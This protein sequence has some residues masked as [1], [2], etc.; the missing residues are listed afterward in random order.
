VQRIQSVKI[1][2]KNTRQP[3]PDG[4]IKTA[5]Q[6]TCPTDA[7]VFGD[8]NDKKAEVAKLQ[9]LPR[10]YSLLGDLNNRPRVQYL[11]RVK[12]PNPELA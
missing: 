5:C 7:I 9:A 8:L 2:A 11:A 4:A 3:I 10:A 1:Q 12:N 6:Q